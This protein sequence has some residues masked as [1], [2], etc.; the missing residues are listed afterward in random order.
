MISFSRD[1][2]LAI[3][4]RGHAALRVFVLALACGLIAF[5]IAKAQPVA[6]GTSSTSQVIKLWD[7]ASRGYQAK[8]K[9]TP[10]AFVLLLLPLSCLAA[11]SGLHNQKRYLRL[12]PAARVSTVNVI[13][14]SRYWFR[15]PPLS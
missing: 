7:E 10:L 9:I 13:S 3:S 12:A 1:M 4:S 14:E 8:L 5:S 2:D 6:A 11:C 15:P